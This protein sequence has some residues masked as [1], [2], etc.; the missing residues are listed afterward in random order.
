MT[1]EIDFSELA[2]IVGCP[3]DVQHEEGFWRAWDD[4][5]LFW[6]MWTKD[7][8]TACIALMHGYGEH[9]TRYHHVGA[10]LAR[11]GFGVMTIDARGHGK[12]GGVRGHIDAFD[13]FVRDLD[14]LITQTQKRFGKPVFVL[15]HSNGGLISLRHA[16]TQRADVVGYAVTSPFCGF[17]VHV[18]AAKALAGNVMSKL[19]GTFAIPTGL[20]AAML[21]HRK[22]VVDLYRNDPLN[23]TKAT[24]RW[25]TETKHAQADLLARAGTIT[26]PFLFLVAGADELVDPMASEKIYHAMDSMDREYEV[27]PTLFH[28][29]LNEDSWTEHVTHIADWMHKRTP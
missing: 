8:P 25:F 3:A 18:P 19:W 13:H 16:L 2:P 4:T 1:T 27:F 9:S 29:I 26:Q 24:A 5:E 7:D 14:Q 21:S 11:A 28:E 12:S 15:G 6:Q 10:A 17:K 23:L 22:E 20:D